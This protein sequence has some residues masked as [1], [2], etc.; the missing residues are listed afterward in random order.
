MFTLLNNFMQQKPAHN[1]KNCSQENNQHI[2]LPQTKGA[3]HSN[4]A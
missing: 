1:K 3:L 2:T 4:M